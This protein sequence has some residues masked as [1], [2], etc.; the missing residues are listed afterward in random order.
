[1]GARTNLLVRKKLLALLSFAISMGLFA[2]TT[3]A[4]N[5]TQIEVESSSKENTIDENSSD[6]TALEEADSKHE[7]T[8]YS[9]NSDNSIDNTSSD[10]ES[11]INVIPP[12]K[13]I[14]PFK[15]LSPESVSGGEVESEAHSGTS[16]PVGSQN[17]EVYVQ[18]GVV[19]SSDS[20]VRVRVR[21]NSN[22]EVNGD[23]L[24]Q[25]DSHF[26]LEIKENTTAN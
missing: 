11:S 24:D 3:Y 6:S 9:Q 8:N 26:T 7:N 5:S 23:S 17:D 20:K 2:S 19:Q 12:T 25:S 15:P 10:N 4:L 16:Q 18:P 13:P 14:T 21:N 22:S 1:M